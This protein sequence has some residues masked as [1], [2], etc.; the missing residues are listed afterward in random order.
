MHSLHPIIITH[1]VVSNWTWCNPPTLRCWTFLHSTSRSCSSWHFFFFKTCMW[2]N[3]CKSLYLY[4]KRWGH[5]HVTW[6]RGVILEAKKNIWSQ[7]ILDLWD[8]FRKSTQM[9]LHHTT[10]H[11]FC[12]RSLRSKFSVSFY[13]FRRGPFTIIK[14]EKHTC[15]TPKPNIGQLEL[16]TFVVA[17]YLRE[18][19]Y[20]QFQST[21]HPALLPFAQLKLQYV[22]IGISLSHGRAVHLIF[23][24]V[25]VTLSNV[26]GGRGSRC[27]SEQIGQESGLGD[28]EQYAFCTFTRNLYSRPGKIPM[29]S[30][31]LHLGEF[32]S[33][34]TNK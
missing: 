29:I 8:I 28:D 23:T 21:K 18:F 9:F 26:D 32:I 27:S 34:A 13:I 33:L 15:T 25:G 31:L 30:Y 16:W 19:S 6:L 17:S 24:V 4:I 10:R 12:N 5:E 20:A 3:M 2:Y 22:K 14:S 1:V 11:T 7:R